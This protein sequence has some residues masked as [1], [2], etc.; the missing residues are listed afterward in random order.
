MKKHNLK[1]IMIIGLIVVIIL[2]IIPISIRS[3]YETSQSKSDY[4]YELII[5]RKIK[6][7]GTVIEERKYKIV[8]SESQLQ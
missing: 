3:I 5:L 4:G 8:G 7:D 1:R 6:E 2:I